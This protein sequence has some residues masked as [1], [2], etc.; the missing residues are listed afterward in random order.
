MSGITSETATLGFL[1]ALFFYQHSDE[2]LTNWPSGDGK[3]TKTTS[4]A[5]GRTLIRIFSLAALMSTILAISGSGDPVGLT[6]A[7]VLIVCIPCWLFWFASWVASEV[8]RFLLTKVGGSQ[9]QV[10]YIVVGIVKVISY[11][12]ARG[13]AWEKSFDSVASMLGFASPTM[14]FS[15]V[16]FIDGF[17]GSLASWL[18][19][20]WC[21]G[22]V[23]VPFAMALAVYVALVAVVN[24]DTPRSSRSGF[25]HSTMNFDPACCA[26]QG[27]HLTQNLRGLY[28]RM[29]GGARRFSGK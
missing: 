1:V 17:A 6:A 7:L 15:N 10:N 4:I 13:N 18:W 23:E 22:L 3:G 12:S 29:P 25:P 24:R 9:R 27:N 14:R 2:I 26:R 28:Q 5:N 8:K 11:V 19:F 20:C 21:H 16:A